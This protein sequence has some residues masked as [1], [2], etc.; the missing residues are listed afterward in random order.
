MILKVSKR[1]FE[2]VMTIDF[3]KYLGYKTG[4]VL[5]P[6]EVRGMHPNRLAYVGDA[7]YE[8]FVRTYLAYELNEP[9]SK[10]HNRT[11][12]FVRAGAQSKALKSI[13][14]LLLEDELYIVKRGRNAKSANVP[15][16]ADMIEYRRATALESLLGYLCLCGRYER[17]LEIMWCTLGIDE[18]NNKESEDT[19]DK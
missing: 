13:L 1:I 6:G 3:L 15:A 9:V 19:W 7:I 16:G 12:N 10:L 11:V 8:A 17:L 14:P 4:K 2:G 18:R 5:D